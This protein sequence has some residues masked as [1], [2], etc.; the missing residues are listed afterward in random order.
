MMRRIVFAVILFVTSPASAATISRGTT[1]AD[2]QV[3]THSALN[4]EFDIL[5]NEVN[6]S[7][8]AANLAADSVASSELLEGDDYTMQNLILS[9][10][11]PDIRWNPTSGDSFHAGAEYSAAGG[12]IWFLSNVT[13]SQHYLRIRNDHLFE[14]PQY[15]SCTRGLLTGADGKVACKTSQWSLASDVSGNLPV[16]NLN[17]GTSASASTFW[18]GDATWATPSISVADRV[19]RTAGDVATTS[20]TLV[21]FTGATITL[22]TGANPVLLGFSGSYTNDD[23][24]GSTSFNFDVDGTLVLGSNGLVIPTAV[25]NEEALATV[26]TMT[27][28]LTAASHTFKFQWNV[29][30]GDTGTMRCDTGE[31]CVFWVVEVTD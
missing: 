23:G 30:T 1:W 5:F 22:T 6:G 9:T 2:Q 11:G 12:S 26:T 27:A 15:V 16:T 20:T 25:V 3:L 10:T 8:S 13:D 24:T 28:D 14:F 29:S 18:R 21:D 19:I 31:S 17:S 4:S 7:L